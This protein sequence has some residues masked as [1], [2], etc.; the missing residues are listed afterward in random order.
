MG[1]H[2]QSASRIT[3]RTRAAVPAMSVRALRITVLKSAGN[4][5]CDESHDLN[6]EKF[7]ASNVFCSRGGNLRSPSNFRTP[8]RSVAFENFRPWSIGGRGSL[9]PGPP[10]V[11]TN[12]KDQ[13]VRRGQKP[14]HNSAS[15]GLV[16]ATMDAGREL[17]KDRTA[18]SGRKWPGHFHKARWA[19]CI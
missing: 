7:G 5:T 16:M 12:R 19:F 18:Q 9:I 13:H 2:D 4:L 15:C 10:E 11:D 6:A 17:A 8:A 3:G 14:T 1:L